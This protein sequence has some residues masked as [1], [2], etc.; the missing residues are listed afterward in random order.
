MGQFINVPYSGTYSGSG[1]GHDPEIGVFSIVTNG[2]LT[3]SLSKDSAGN[4]SGTW[5]YNGT[6]IVTSA[7]GAETGEIFDAGGVSGTSAN[8]IFISNSG[9]F[10]N[11]I[12]RLDN[13]DTALSMEAGFLF[14]G[15]SGGSSG[16][17][18]GSP[19]TVVPPVVDY[20]SITFSSSAPQVSDWTD[21]S[22]VAAGDTFVSPQYVVDEVTG[23]WSLKSYPGTPGGLFNPA[24]VDYFTG[25]AKDKLCSAVSDAAQEHVDDL[26]KD[27]LGEHQ[28]AALT[29]FFKSAQMAHDY[30]EAVAKLADGTMQILVD[31]PEAIAGLRSPDEIHNRIDTLH[32]E[33]ATDLA[34]IL[35][36]EYVN[37]AIDAI[38][39]FLRRSD[40]TFGMQSGSGAFNGNEHRDLMLGGTSGD[41][42]YGNANDDIAF[43]GQGSDTL[44]GGV[45]ID[46]LYG[47]P[48][49]D[50]LTGGA[51]NDV[52]R[53]DAGIDTVVLAGSKSGYS[54]AKTASG[55]IVT[56]ASD[57]ADT[58]Q[59]VEKLQFAD[60]SVY[61]MSA[62]AELLP[63]SQRKA[64]SE[65][66]VAFFNRVPEASGL[67]YWIEQAANGMSINA[68]AQSFYD[69]AIQYS[70]I[71]GYSASASSD[72]FVRT[73]Y[74]NVLGRSGSTAPGQD[75]VNYWLGELNSGR[76]SKGSLV[77]T[78]LD[79]A[80]GLAGDATWGW[81][82]RLLD[83]KI[84]VAEQHAI[85]L[86]K[87]YATPDESIS[88]TMA[89][90]AAVTAA[91][92]S[93]AITLIGNAGSVLGDGTA[94]L[95]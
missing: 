34:K 81:V 7:D 3:A 22:T 15:G 78:M 49:A 84:T 19:G 20:S 1:S 75:E 2:T 23:A 9:V 39:W 73:I 35:L 60:G 74:A 79:A 29:S 76:A 11:G 47:G 5:Y 55:Y 69:A 44:D 17:M 45:G 36:P 70:T 18:S 58:L 50:R 64:L 67:A 57:G 86:A 37:D 92:T 59:S 66:Y 65:L 32:E 40:Y 10:V 91:D 13:N 62:V 71:T 82:T 63:V 31:A 16:T 80:R 41:V 52:L 68:M 88:R 51:G 54:V 42:F 85:T 27:T 12:G 87:G 4:V 33:F 38:K 46:N 30:Y 93:A 83:N 14:G 43:G 21:S 56:N 24:D 25:L 28:G 77:T 61:L 72:S 95:S 94:A 6:A 90:A 53:G 8:L 48:G 26:I 89:I